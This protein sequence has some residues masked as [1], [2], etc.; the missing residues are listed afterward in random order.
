MSSRR[1]MF[2]LMAA[3]LLSASA[4]TGR[5]DDPK[6]PANNPPPAA[7]MYACPMHPQIQATFPGS[8]PICRMALQP[9]GS[10]PAAA[11]APMNYADHAHPGMNMG[12]TDMEMMNCPH[13]MMGMG[14]MSGMGSM[15]TKGAP[16]A[17]MAPG[18]VAPAGYRAV[19]G[20][21][22]GC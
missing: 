21:R 19:G 7:A 11:A 14:G 15:S 1:L 8:C 13:C 12:G 4:L 22:C 3:G 5:A 10:S 16:A 18:K 6:T 17:R 2:G 9:K 20:R